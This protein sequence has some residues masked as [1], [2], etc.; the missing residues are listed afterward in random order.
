M[1]IRHLE[2]LRGRAYR[3]PEPGAGGNTS[4]SKVETFSR[5]YVH[6]LREESNANRQRAQESD[7]AKKAAEEAAAR[8]KTDSDTRVKEVQSAA[9]K[10]VI[11]AEAKTEAVKAG[12]VDIDGLNLAD[13]SKVKIND[14]GEVEGVEELIKQL[15]KDK[16]YLFSAPSTSSTEKTPKPGDQKA[17]K[18][19]EM[20]DEER[21]AEARRLGITGRV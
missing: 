12:I 20:T 17:K 3:D 18:V 8:A 7:N 1:L 4:P 11:R 19:S 21:R 5:E 16:P 10:R 2:L 13:F 9:D 14:K 6:E 15:K